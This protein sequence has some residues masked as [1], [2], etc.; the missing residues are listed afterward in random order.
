ML[1]NIIIMMNSYLW[2][3]DNYANSSEGINV[4]VGN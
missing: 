4:I 3:L 1:P 2:V